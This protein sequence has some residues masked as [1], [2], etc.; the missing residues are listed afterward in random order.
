MCFSR[1]SSKDP[2]GYGPGFRG[3][4]PVFTDFDVHVDVVESSGD[5]ADVN[6]NDRLANTTSVVSN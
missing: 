2:D 4:I 1:A 3:E 5:I 6:R